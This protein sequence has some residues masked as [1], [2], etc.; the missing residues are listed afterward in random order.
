MDKNEIE[1]RMNAA[2][3]LVAWLD[4]RIA[5]Q[6]EQQVQQRVEWEREKW[7]GFLVDLF[8]E[9]RK[10]VFALLEKEVAELVGRSHD[11]MIDRT[12]QML[13]R[14]GQMLDRVEAKLDE[15]MHR[16]GDDTPPL[17]H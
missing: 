3:D 1:K 16:S 10:E 7:R 13:E 9:E 14:V 6:V 11:K 5:Q 8:V 12:K 2:V 17:K 15:P 4:Q